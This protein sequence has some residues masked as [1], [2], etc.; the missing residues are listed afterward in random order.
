MNLQSKILTDDLIESARGLT[1][2][3]GFVNRM[4]LPLPTSRPPVIFSPG[5]C[6]SNVYWAI[7]QNEYHSKGGITYRHHDFDSN[8]D[9]YQIAHSKF[10]YMLLRKDINEYVL[11]KLVSDHF[12]LMISEDANLERHTIEVQS[13][14]P[15]LATQ[16]KVHNCI[17]SILYFL[18]YALLLLYAKKE[19]SL[20]Y[21]E[22]LDLTQMVAPIRKNPYD[23]HHLVENAD[24]VFKW[25]ND[26]ENT[27]TIQSVFARFEGI[28]IG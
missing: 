4:T 10:V 18:D 3:P 19:M 2:A 15:F 24:E 13:W 1:K 16:L 25:I 23:K 6:G 20:A 8:E 9:F 14:Q 26:Y 27:T 28:R 7:L 21:F 11:S 22:D 12:R 5:R 17:D